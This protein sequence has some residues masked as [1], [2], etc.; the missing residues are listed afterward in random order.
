MNDIL[1]FQIRHR[2]RHQH[3]I[4]L[5]IR[6]GQ[7]PFDKACSICYLSSENPSNQFKRFYQWISQE[8][9]VYSHTSLSEQYFAELNQYYNI[10]R[11]EDLDV[12]KAKRLAI[13][14]V[15]SLE[16]SNFFKLDVI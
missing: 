2:H 7:L 11:L 16:F 1:Y 14:L 12:D 10:D 5:D 9:K 4:N 13:S 3:L 6:R 15:F 8:H